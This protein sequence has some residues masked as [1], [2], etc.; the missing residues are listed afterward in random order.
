MT[1]IFVDGD[2]CP[3]VNEIIDLTAET[4]FFVTILRSFSHFSHSHYPSHVIIQLVTTSDIVITQDYGLASLLLKKARI[5]MH[6]KGFIYNENNIDIL[7]QQRYNNAQIRK[8][9]G[10]HK[11]PSPF[12]KADR[13]H[14]C[15]VF[16]TLLNQLMEDTK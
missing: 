6:H 13:Q 12:S 8:Q 5:I 16:Q 4:G 9:G 11:G 10:R 3:V 7:L 1:T 14:F 15:D 2:A